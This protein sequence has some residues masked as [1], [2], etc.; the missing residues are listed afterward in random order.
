MFSEPWEGNIILIT[1]RLPS[2]ASVFILFS[3]EN[4]LSCSY[5][6]RPCSELIF[7][8]CLSFISHYITLTCIVAPFSLLPHTFPH[9]LWLGFKFLDILSF[10]LYI[11]T[12]YLI[13][14]RFVT[15]LVLASLSVSAFAAQSCSSSSQCN[16]KYP[17]CSRE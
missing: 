9:F 15:P 13:M 7:T 4:L 14:V 5:N 12:V 1:I 16:E 11:P 10:P 6:Y 8:C 3:S 17:C 2:R